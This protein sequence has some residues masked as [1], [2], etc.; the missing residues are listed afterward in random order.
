MELIYTEPGR[1]AEKHMSALKPQTLNPEP[2]R[3][4]PKTQHDSIT[5]HGFQLRHDLGAETNV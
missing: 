2:Y 4:N 1:S 3:P 5:V